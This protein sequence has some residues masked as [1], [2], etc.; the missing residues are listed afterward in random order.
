MYHGL[1]FPATTRAATRSN[2][3]S[4]NTATMGEE[5]WTWVAATRPLGPRADWAAELRWA[6]SLSHLAQLLDDRGLRRGRLKRPN[7]PHLGAGL[8]DPP[9][10]NKQLR[11]RKRGRHVQRT[12]RYSALMGSAG[13]L[14]RT[15][16]RVSLIVA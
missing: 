11:P 1:Q 4:T 10:T 9:A 14:P 5:L 13:G 12:D 8:G 15:L 6:L 2:M 16:R 3:T 7:W